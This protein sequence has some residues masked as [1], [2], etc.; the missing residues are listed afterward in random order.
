LPVITDININN[1]CRLAVWEITED[2]KSLASQLILSEDEK[3]FLSEIKVEKKKLQ[4]LASRCLIRMIVNVKEYISMHASDEGQPMMSNLKQKVSISHAGKYAAVIMSKENNV[5]IDVEIISDK[6]LAIKE[7]FIG[8]AEL[9][10]MR[11]EKN[12][13]KPLLIWSAKESMFKW[14]GK[15]CVDFKENLLLEKFELEKSGTIKANFNHRLKKQALVINYEVKKDFVIT[16][17]Y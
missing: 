17:V 13:L 11:E 1:N 15:G 4:W 10:W 9:T 5:G 3:E 6:V 14:Y 12:F 7:K 16:W 2:E 8:E